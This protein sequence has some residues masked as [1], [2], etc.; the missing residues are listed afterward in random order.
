MD[1]VQKYIQDEINEKAILGPF[2]QLPYHNVHI[3]PLMTRPKEGTKRRV[4]VDLSY[5][6]EYGRSVNSVT[7]TDIYLGTAYSFKLP[8]VDTICDF[9]NNVGGPVKLFKVNL[10][11][12][13]R[14]LKIDPV[15]IFNLGLKVEGKY[16]LDGHCLSDGGA[17]R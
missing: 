8:M 3:S 5:P 9:I 14:Q 15:Y 4:I 16:Y 12:A 7:S 17:D 11:H 2:D 6:Y 13:F 10:A 1:S